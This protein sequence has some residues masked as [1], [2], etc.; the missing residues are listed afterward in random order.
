[1]YE[2]ASPLWTRNSP[3]AQK[4]FLIWSDSSFRQPWEAA[5]N[6]GKLSISRCKCIETSPRSSS[7][8]CL[9]V[10]A[11]KIVPFCETMNNRRRY[12]SRSLRGVSEFVYLR[13]DIFKFPN[14]V[15]L[16]WD[17]LWASETFVSKERREISKSETLYLVYV[18]AV[19]Q[20]PHGLKVILHSLLKFL[21]DLV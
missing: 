6:I 7:G 17:Y 15:D 1:M 11:R 19:I 13:I 16:F 3:G 12:I 4:L 14:N 5:S 18:D 8:N 9:S 2:S 10:C 21:R 20:R